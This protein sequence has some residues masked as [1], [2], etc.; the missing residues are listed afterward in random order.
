MSDCGAFDTLWEGRR[1]A[2]LSLRKH[3]ICLCIYS[4]WKM[5]NTDQVMEGQN[6]DILAFNHCVV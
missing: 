5:Q 4:A 2:N 3:P 6:R 1:R